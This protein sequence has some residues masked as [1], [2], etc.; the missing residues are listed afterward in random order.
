MTNKHTPGPWEITKAEREEY[1]IEDVHYNVG[2]AIGIKSIEDAN[3]IAAAPDL[4]KALEILLAQVKP[5]TDGDGAAMYHAQNIA[6][7]AIKRAKGE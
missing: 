6:A 2:P 5:Y 7:K 4:L 3:L 1:W